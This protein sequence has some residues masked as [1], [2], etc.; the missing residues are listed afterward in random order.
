MLLFLVAFNFLSPTIT[1]WKKDHIS[2]DFL[3]NRITKN[4]AVVRLIYDTSLVLVA[5][6]VVSI[7]LPVVYSF[8]SV[9]LKYPEYAQLV[10][11][12]NI[13]WLKIVLFAAS[14]LVLLHLL[15][16]LIKD[17]SDFRKVHRSGSRS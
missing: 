17:A 6:V 7:F 8:M 9:G 13:S 16:I 10:P 11:W 4:R 15:V 1:T 3:P 5:I 2:V 14:C 12:F